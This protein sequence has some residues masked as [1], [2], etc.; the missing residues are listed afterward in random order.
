MK[1]LNL[2]ELLEIHQEEDT[3]T[4]TAKKYCDKHDISYSDSIRRKVSKLL[5]SV[6][7]DTDLDTETTTDTAQ[8]ENLTSG[9][10]V[11]MPSA[12]SSINNRFFTIEEYC[13]EYGLDMSTVKSSKLVSH[14]AS[15]MIYNIAFYTPE[16]E[17]VINVQDGLEDIVQ[18]YIKPQERFVEGYEIPYDRWFDRL[19]Y[20]DVH[21]AMDVNA[22]G[23]PLY[24]GKWDREE[25]FKRL[26]IMIKHVLS[27]KKSNTLYIDDLGDFLDGLG[28]Q[29]TRGGHHLP[30]NMNDKQAFDLALEFKMSLLDSLIDKYDYIVCNNITE[31]NHAGVFGY[32]A[33]SAFKQIAEQKYPNKVEV[34]NFKRFIEH[35]KVGRHT[36]VEC[37]GKDS[38]SLKFG[39]KPF[40]DPKQA[41]KID[42]YCKEHKLYDGNYVEFGKGDSHQAVFD[43][44][45]SNDYNYYNYPS[46]APPSNWVKSNFKN[47]KSGFRFFNIDK[48]SQI[49]IHIPYYFE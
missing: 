47:S 46:L 39:F 10:G 34:N 27:F 11:S 1:E 20:T 26:D 12:W 5:N 16:E 45:S 49:K 42:Q 30:Q 13:E 33:A 22:D 32:F 44:T 7:V 40:L 19:V 36:F 15:H 43:E 29:T 3:I 25:V 38:V 37:H 6:T 2:K 14:N 48:E 23:D 28:S 9:S 24:D 41:E 17:A 21:I 31:D 18:K 8:Y 35:Y 4:Q